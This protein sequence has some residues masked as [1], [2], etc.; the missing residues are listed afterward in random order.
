MSAQLIANAV[1]N[2]EAQ[3]ESTI[4]DRIYAFWLRRLVYTQIWEDPEA[5]QIGRAHV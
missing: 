5:D 2:R 1:R 4:W 3:H